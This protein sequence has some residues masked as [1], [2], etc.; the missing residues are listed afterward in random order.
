MKQYK[1]LYKL[2]GRDWFLHEVKC[3]SDQITYF[4]IKVDYQKVEI[5]ICEIIN[6]DS[7][8]HLLGV[9]GI[10]FQDNY[11]LTLGDFLSRF[12]MPS[13]EDYL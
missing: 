4:L 11:Y 12:S 8:K 5:K 10:E 1:T 2:S 9:A 6:I 13:S 3:A 7:F